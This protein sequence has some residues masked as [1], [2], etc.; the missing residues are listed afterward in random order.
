MEIWQKAFLDEEIDRFKKEYITGSGLT[1]TNNEIKDIIKVIK[2]L[3]NREILLK[4]TNRKITRQEERFFNLLRPL[5]TA[6]L[7]LMK[8]VL[9]LLA[10]NVL[11]LFRLSAGKSAADAAIQKKIYGSWNT[12]LIISNEEMED[13]MK[14]VKSLEKSGLPVKGISEKIKNETK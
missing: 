3:R 4:W 10:K 6:G 14:I 5:M 13:I 8:N 11:L 9:L 1:L 12:A 7:S 2:A